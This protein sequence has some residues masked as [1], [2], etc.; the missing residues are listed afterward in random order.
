MLSIS[1]FLAIVQPTTIIV[2]DAAELRRAAGNAK[3]GH[4][5]L[6]APGD[7]QGG[8]HLV[9][10]RGTAEAQITISAQDPKRPPRFLRGGSGLQLSSVAHIEISHL[11]IEDATGNGLNVDDGGREASSHDLTIRHIRVSRLPKG[12]HDGIKLSGIRKFRVESCQISDWGGSGIDMVGC[13]QG[14]IDRCSFSRGGDNGIQAKGGSQFVIITG[15]RFVEPGQRGVNIGGSTGRE[16]FRPPLATIPEG[17]RFEAKQIV[18]EHCAFRGGMAPVAFVGSDESL[19]RRN[20]IFDPGR[21]AVRILQETTGPDF[22]PCRY[23][24]F[25][26]NIVVFRSARWAAGGVNVG[27]GTQPDTF[28]FA[29]NL[30][31]CLDQPGRSRPSLPTAEKGGVYGQD[32]KLADP[33]QGDFRVQA[34]GLQAYGADSSRLAPVVK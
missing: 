6:L 21:W 17:Q 34:A 10:L 5:I 7:Y 31:Y 1:L 30:W 29:K 18:V 2:K 27:G 20:T 28:G 24:A 19:F 23:G 14:V 33:E 13:H 26:E 3:P 11:V 32:P 8:V 25:E 4:R 16:F 15:C 9:G 22:L 12:N